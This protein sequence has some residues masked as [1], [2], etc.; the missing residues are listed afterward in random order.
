MKFLCA[1]LILYPLIANGQL[2]AVS[3][4]LRHKNNIIKSLKNN[5]DSSMDYFATSEIH[6][7]RYF[8]EP[9][10]DELLAMWR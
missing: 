8:N 9:N 6:E 3:R 4:V 5:P 2:F 1:F 7:N 10:C